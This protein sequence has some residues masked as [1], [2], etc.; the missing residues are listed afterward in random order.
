MVRKKV[1][2]ALGHLG[3]TQS[4]VIDALLIATSDSAYQVRQA[5]IEAFGRLGDTQPRIMD[6]L[7]IALL[8]DVDIRAAAIE[9]CG[10]IGKGQQRV[11]D[12]L[13]VALIDID[14]FKIRRAAAYGLAKIGQGYPQVADA[15]L[16][17]L[18]DADIDVRE[19]AGYALSQMELKNKKE[20]IDTL[21]SADPN[22]L[23][24]EIE[25][26]AKITQLFGH[27]SSSFIRSIIC[28]A[29]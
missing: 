13:L 24:E 2:I 28:I 29:S 4:E 12:T 11:I 10:L 17:A 23:T 22:S 3:N 20:V 9:A 8:D 26:V 5:A 14:N 6:A 27:P 16:L 19:A 1:I 15:L 18:A 25:I 21:L 7:F